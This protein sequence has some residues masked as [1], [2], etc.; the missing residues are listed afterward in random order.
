MNELIK[1]LAVKSYDTTFIKCKEVEYKVGEV[2]GVFTGYAMQE[3]H[4]LTVKEC[5]Q[6]LIDHGYDDAA[7][8]LTKELTNENSH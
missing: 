7:N 4:H 3:M 5:I 1:K 2:D 8:C 6:K